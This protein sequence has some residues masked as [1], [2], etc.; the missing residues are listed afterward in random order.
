DRAVQ[1]GPRPPLRPALATVAAAV[2][3]GRR[4]RRHPYLRRRRAGDHRAVRLR[5][6]RAA[7]EARLGRRAVRALPRPP[8]RA[9]DAAAPRTAGQLVAVG[10]LPS[11][12]T[13]A[14]AEW[15]GD[16]WRGNVRPAV[17]DRETGACRTDERD[18]SRPGQGDAVAPSAAGLALADGYPLFWFDETGQ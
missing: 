5:R 9:G 16:Q 3:P 18:L 1:G 12:R 17:W 10:F 13:V 7:G 4:P 2:P 8:R 6:G 11:G 15:S 14:A